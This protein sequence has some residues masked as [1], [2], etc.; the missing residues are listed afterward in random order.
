M[1]ICILNFLSKVQSCVGKDFTSAQ[2]KKLVSLL[3]K[4]KELFGEK[5][6]LTNLV[7]H[8]IENSSVI[9]HRQRKLAI[10]EEEQ[11]DKLTT[12]MLKDK[13]VRA[14]SSPYNS[15]ILLVTKRMAR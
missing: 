14:S 12:Q 15:P 10:A 4:H 1:V 2:R 13:L 7:T 3:Q 9:F 5:K 6:G 8:K 11:A